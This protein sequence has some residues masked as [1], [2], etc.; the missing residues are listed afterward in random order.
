MVATSA[1][2]GTSRQSFNYEAPTSGLYFIEV[3]VP[4]TMPVGGG[5]SL[6]SSIL[7]QRVSDLTGPSNARRGKGFALSGYVTPEH[8]GK[9]VMYAYRLSGRKWILAKTLALPLTPDVS[10]DRA[11]FR[12]RF[13]VSAGRYRFRVLHTSGQAVIHSNWK[14]VVVK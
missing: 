5:Y 6:E 1:A 8:I 9:T 2:A 4:E 10:L 11:S 7:T 12:A 14:Y 13:T 3:Y